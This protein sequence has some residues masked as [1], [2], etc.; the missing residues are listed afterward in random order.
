MTMSL[1][2]V[3]GGGM[4]TDQERPAPT[5][6]TTATASDPSVGSTAD[7]TASRTLAVDSQT[8]EECVVDSSG[9]AYPELV[10]LR[11]TETESGNA[12]LAIGGSDG[13]AY[14]MYLE[15]PP[16]SSSEGILGRGGEVIVRYGNIEIPR[17]ERFAQQWSNS[18]STFDDEIAIVRH[19]SIA[20][21]YS[22]NLKKI[23]F[24]AHRPGSIFQSIPP[25]VYDIRVVVYQKTTVQNAKSAFPVEA[26]RNAP[27][28]ESELTVELGD[29]EVDYAAEERLENIDEKLLDNYEEL[30]E[31]R[32]KYSDA[33][34]SFGIT[35]GK[36][37]A[38][39]LAKEFIRRGN[40]KKR[41][42][43]ILKKSFGTISAKGAIENAESLWKDWDKG[44]E[45][46]AE[47]DG[48]VS[49]IKELQS[50]KS[51]IL[52]GVERCNGEGYSIDN[53][54]GL[55]PSEVQEAIN[56]GASG[57]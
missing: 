28:R 20:A 29:C 33:R 6:E 56:L 37:T 43:Q 48:R 45:A 2:P 42:K 55:S 21:D 3:T 34:L 14:V 19:S 9:S 18:L 25:G 53:Y 50:Q 22:D 35:T 40:L 7:R 10:E 23:Y 57:P 15:I 41:G 32:E 16:G 51:A 46:Q 24:F 12:S 44:A 30:G 13:W 47:F 1:V 4:P 54:D 52:D 49:D 38:Q 27:R 31:A 39:I 5:G 11:C 26:I 17:P 8:D 36:T